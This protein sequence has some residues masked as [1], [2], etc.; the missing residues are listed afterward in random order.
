MDNGDAGTASAK[1]GTKKYIKTKF[2]EMYGIK[3]LEKI[4]ISDLIKVCNISRGTF[5]FYFADIFVLYH[6]CEQD[7]IDILEAEHAGIN[8]STVRSQYDEHIKI[9]S[10]YL[11]RYVIHIDMLDRFLKG[12][13]NVS[14]M[15]A[16]FESIC[17]IYAESMEFSQAASLKEKECLS[18]FFAGGLQALL[19]DWIQGGCEDPIENIAEIVARALYLGMFPK[20]D[21]KPVHAQ[22]IIPALRLRSK[23]IPEE[24]Q[25]MTD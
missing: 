16:W 20:A 6:E 4:K 23:T 25:A 10:R 22:R 24:L 9:Y 15:C 2:L 17:R 18:R 1:R 11:E 12:S 7:M 14:F 5:Y 3:S 13:E 8:L 21:S 19:V